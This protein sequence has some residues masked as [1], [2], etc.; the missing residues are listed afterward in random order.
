[1]VECQ[2]PKLNVA[3]S[4]PVTRLSTIGSRSRLDQLHDLWTGTSGTALTIKTF[5]NQGTCFSDL[6]GFRNNPRLLEITFSR[7]SVGLALLSSVSG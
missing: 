2:L 3:G 6:S 7:K 1:M 5:E 4:N